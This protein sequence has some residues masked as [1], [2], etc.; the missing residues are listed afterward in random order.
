MDNKNQVA[1]RYEDENKNLL[2]RKIR[3]NSA[4]G[5]KKFYFEQEKNGQIITNI[6]GCRR[7]LYHLPQL[8]YGISKEQTIFLVE[9]EKDVETLLKHI[10]FATTT[11]TSLEWDENY[12][13]I[14]K[15]ANVVVLYDN[16]KTGLQRKE[17]LCKSLYGQ[18]KSLKVVDL[19]GIEYREKHG[20]DITDWLEMGHTTDELEELV[21][22]TLEYKPPRDNNS[23]RVVSLDELLTIVLPERE[24]LLMPFLPSQGL[25]LLVAKR[26][27]GKTHIAL[28][29]AYAVATGNTFLRW[30]APVAKKVLYLDGE[31][32]AVLM[33]ERLKMI[34]TM[35]PKE[36]DSE[37]FKFM[38][39]D[40]QTRV[41]PDLATEEGRK[42]IEEFIQDRDL[43]V[44]DN[45]SCLFRSGNENESEGWQQ[46]QEWA[47]DLRR[48]GKSVLF[49]HHAGKNGAQR[50]TSKREDILDTVIMLKHPDDYKAEEGA[51]F[52]VS[53]DKA[54]HFTGADASSFQVQLLED[55]YGVWT[56]ELSDTPEE[57]Q[58][59]QIADM[60]NSGL[61]IKEICKQTK[62]T[63]SQV[64]WRLSKAKTK[65][66][67]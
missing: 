9:G 49:V 41:M 28:G 48:R 30:T 31:M 22:K 26:G 34:K 62:L 1:Y 25:V 46:A 6:D 27:V 56:W 29:I 19:P 38:T 13:Q 33:Q 57:A 24:M 35:M 53:F 3:I 12:T 20:Q 67:I 61:T 55:D 59:L 21:E 7:V 44:I 39:P 52:E 23:L 63:K 4:N 14:L 45:I 47:L 37:F 65:S 11:I 2:F 50:G 66:L 16:D 10:I 32:P 8:L 43:I 64:E 51:R 58:I 15:D 40:L 5:T 60:K 18:V 17:L 36:A 42:M 54:R